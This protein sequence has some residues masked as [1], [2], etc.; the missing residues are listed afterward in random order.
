MW[1]F[2]SLTAASPKAHA[3][4]KLRRKE[5]ENWALEAYGLLQLPC[6]IFNLR[7]ER[8]CSE[9]NEILDTH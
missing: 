6:C 1:I 4:C 3:L 9:C 7:Q 8:K 5:L 2:F